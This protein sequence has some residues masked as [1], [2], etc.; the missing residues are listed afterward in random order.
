MIAPRRTRLLR[1]TDLQTFQHT[2]VDL[3]GMRDPT[4]ARKTAVLVPT[5]AAAAHLRRTLEQALVRAPGDAC[6]WT[7]P[8][9]VTRDGWY[10]AM[11][12]HRVDLPTLLTA[13][14]R[15]VCMLSAARTVVQDELVPP[16][17][18]HAGLA[19]SFVQ[20]YDELRRYRRTVDAFERLTTEDL[21]PSVDLDRGARRLL[22][23]TRFLAATFRAYEQRLG[24]A[25][26]LDE[27]GL[28]E[29][30]DEATGT[31]FER[32]VVT[33]A[34]HVAQPGG[35]WPA[36]YDVLTRLPGLTQIEVVATERVLAAGFMDRLA[37]QLPGIEDHPVDSSTSRH[38]KLVGPSEDSPY[39][40]WRDREEELRAV[41]RSVKKMGQGTGAADGTGPSTVSTR[42]GVVYRRPLPYL[43]PARHLFDQAGVPFESHDAL[44]LASEPYAA[45]LD[46]AC[47]FALSGFDRPSTVALIGSPHFSFFPSAD[48]LRPFAAE[49]L[50]RALREARFSGGYQELTRL[51]S[52]WAAEDARSREQ[53]PEAV[54]VGVAARLASELADLTGEQPAHAMFDVLGGFLVRYSG[55]QDD[56]DGPEGRE[57]RA[58]L[59]IW[60]GIDDLANAHRQL[61][62]SAT[63]FTDVVSILRRWLEAQTFRPSPGGDGVQ[64]LDASAAAYGS[65]DT[66]TIV[67]VVDRE[68]PELGGRNIFYP[69]SLLRPL[70]WP[71]DQDRYRAARAAFRD[72]VELPRE[73]VGVST[74]SLENDA[75]V[76]P[77][78]L[79]E[80][81]DDLGFQPVHTNVDPDAV[82]TPDDALSRGL[83]MPF[84]PATPLG[85]WTAARERD[86][87]PDESRFP[88]FVGPRPPSTYAVKA[89]EEYLECPFK[90]LARR[91]LRLGDEPPDERRAAPLRRGL[92]LHRVLEAFFRN[93]ND[94]GHR[95]VTVSTFDEAV[96]R[97][98]QIAEGELRTLRPSDRAVMRSWMLGSAGSAGL[99]ERL[100]RWEVERPAE[101]VDRLIEVRLDAEYVL[102]GEHGPR[103]VAL[104]GVADRV[105]LFSNGTFRVVDYKAN[106][107]PDRKRALQ[108]LLYATCLEQ[109]LTRRD[110]RQW[111]A[112]EVAYAA[113]GEPRLHKPLARSDLES[114]LTEGQRRA[115]AVV[116]AI[117]RGEY[118]VRPA[119]LFGCNFCAYPTVCRKNYVGDE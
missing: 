42:V 76:L 1:A 29:A 114:R 67:G 58:R 22:R 12:E 32:V 46:L 64:L 23:Q 79:L 110:G 36:D 118:P 20:F 5:T 78:G 17:R 63:T 116:D 56:A 11:H 10:R 13:I 106:R 45:A 35:L 117:E 49:N 65:F 38:P 34:D 98:H 69:S 3:L 25:G 8:R 30:L 33:V 77:S 113:F 26:S 39:F 43:Y 47:E 41:V 19:R 111:R 80:D 16:F 93:W 100:L 21:E 18:L 95:A 2:L 54:Q 92:F 103:P 115:I 119:E 24:E 108:L 109:E 48:R 97:F 85:T 31:C 86:R 6:A 101:L 66:L 94:Q 73:S 74:F 44:P 50:D 84:D 15:Q 104:R 57:Q 68:W 91:V 87:D 28:R 112:A 99:V 40:A 53:R 61:D 71:S 9:F 107:A 75:V 27:H 51:A 89:L 70:G 88:G 102:A 96:S 72:L 62:R 83:D 37:E 55:S 7:M 82:V 14:E 4:V 105:D 81:L 52:V 90:Y 59:A 60:R